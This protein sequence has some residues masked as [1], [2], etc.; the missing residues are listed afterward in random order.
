MRQKKT[1]SPP[2][3]CFPNFS[4]SFGGN[5]VGGDANGQTHKGAL[6]TEARAEVSFLAG[7]AAAN[8]AQ[9]QWMAQLATHPNLAGASAS[10]PQNLAGTIDPNDSESN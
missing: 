7:M 1:P 5:K 4:R 9:Q 10:S 3:T 8:R 2:T 6:D